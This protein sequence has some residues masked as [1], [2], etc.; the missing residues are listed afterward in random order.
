MPPTLPA[1][2]TGANYGDPH[3]VTLDGLAYDFQAV[4]EF[5]LIEAASGD[6]LQVQVR[7]EPVDGSQVASQ[8]TAVATTLGT[9]RVVIDANSSSLVSVDGATFDL[10]SAVGGASVGDGE[11]YFDGEAI[12][13]VYANGEQLRVDIYDGFLSTSVSV[14]AGRDVRGL[15]GNADGDTGNDLALR[16]GTVLAQPVSFADLYGAFA[17]DWRI[18]DATSLFDYAAGQGTADYTDTSFPAASIS[19]DD[20]PVEVVA[21]A[22]AAAAG[23]ADPVLRE[24]AILDY[25]L[26]G[27]SDF[28]AAAGT[29]DEGLGG[30][31]TDT[32]PADAPSIL[33]GIGIGVSEA[34]ITE[35][36]SGA[37][38]VTFTIYRTGD[39]SEA[40]DVAYAVGGDV[41][42][43]DVAGA[44]SGNV[45]FAA[46]EAS[47]EI[48]LDILGDTAV[49]DNEVLEMSFTLG[50]VGQP[51]VL[52][53]IARVTIV[54]DDIA[55]PEPELNPVEGTRRSDF[56]V[57]TDGND[58]ITG[59]G[60]AFD[61]LFGRG[62]ADTFVFGAE[63]DNGR[64]DRD[65]I[66]DYEAGVDQIL[67][68]EGAAI[69]SI[70]DTW[71]GVLIT[72]E[73]DRDKLNILGSDLDPN[74]IT[75]VYDDMQIA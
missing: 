23:I 74:D 69:R 55:A 37:T 47:R 49:E 33:S 8:T 51:I 65:V 70:R 28:I 66:F 46:G 13:L 32:A 34:R 73:E 57:G 5:T 39:L 1:G 9:A 11:I 43:D 20:F 42:G 71:S 44:L 19:L 41:D 4:G 6:P 52:S 21:A 18:T 50:G 12:T 16:D 68:T 59:Y 26:S 30:A 54:N 27:N 25:L 45:S 29:V 62:G 38:A 36:D 40:V 61:L 35:G 10:D 67:L 7:F 14:A 60:G 15:L 64:R 24:A 53:S 3:I 22:E 17:D 63:T 75:I 31:L 2:A 72:F 56:L 48:A 58:L